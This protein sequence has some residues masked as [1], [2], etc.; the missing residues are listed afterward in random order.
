MFP[1]CLEDFPIPD[2]RDKEF[3]NGCI[4]VELW[5]YKFMQSDKLVGT[6]IISL[7]HLYGQTNYSGTIEK[8][9]KDQGKTIIMNVSFPNSPSTR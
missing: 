4:L 8:Y 3:H 9:Y 5:K 7:K 1:V 2:N 6:D